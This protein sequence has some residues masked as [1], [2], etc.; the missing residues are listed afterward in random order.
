VSL[1]VGDRS[2]LAGSEPTESHWAVTNADESQDRMADCAVKTTHFVVST[3]SNRDEAP[4]PR[5]H[6]AAS[7]ILRKIVVT[8]HASRLNR[9]CPAVGEANACPQSL[10]L[11]L[12]NHGFCCRCIGSAQSGTW[13]RKWR[14]NTSLFGQKQQ[15]FALA[16]ESPD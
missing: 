11:C 4:L 10:E 13:V 14:N 16:I 6:I 12:P 15:P 2:Q 1:G 7:N 8:V 9:M 5:V 3:L